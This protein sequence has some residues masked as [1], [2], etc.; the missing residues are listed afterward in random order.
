MKKIILL[1]LLLAS[2]LSLVA[3]ND[4]LPAFPGADGYGR[5]VTGGRGGKIL[6]VTN[7]ND[8]GQGSLRWAIAQSGARIIVFDVSG[9]IELK[10]QLSIKNGNLTI[11][12]QTAPGDGICLKGHTL[13][14]DAHNVIIRYIR[15]RMGDERAVENDAMWGRNR[16]GIILDHCTM[17]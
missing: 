8:T 5:Y 7:L 17:S 4:S 16:K 12:G 3:Q 15:C 10:S 9:T 13:N 11:A 6:H 1:S 14:L 2:G